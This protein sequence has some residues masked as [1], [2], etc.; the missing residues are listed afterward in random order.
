MSRDESHRRLT[1]V[2]PGTEMGELLR[3]YWHPIEAL[4]ELE[5]DPL[6]PIRILGEDLL[7]YRDRSG[8]L[9]LVDRHCPHRGA[10]LLYGILESRGVRCSYHGWHFDERGRC[11]ARPF[12]EVARP[13]ARGEAGVAIKAYPVA[14]KASLV[15]AYLGPPPAPC[16]WD[17]ARFHDPGHPVV[18]L[19][20]L[21]CN[22]LQCQ[23]NTVDPVHV[24]WL[25][26]AL[27]G[28]RYGHGER[29]A[30]HRKIGFD[31]FEFGFVYRGVLDN[32]DESHPLWTGGSASL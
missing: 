22:W 31:E 18:S 2:G 1:R 5:R 10:D 29:G 23:E 30:R 15:W 8:T 24:E 11:L 21:P 3:R 4:L 9:G 28:A 16:L 12:D 14:V 26:Q 6:Q 13:G 7:L 17:W 20:L 32:T 25:H 27:P 19:A